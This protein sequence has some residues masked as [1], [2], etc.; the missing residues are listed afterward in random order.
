MLLIQ[1]FLSGLDYEP[2]DDVIDHKSG[3]IVQK[4]MDLSNLNLKLLTLAFV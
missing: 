4:S 1:N 2:L 3:V